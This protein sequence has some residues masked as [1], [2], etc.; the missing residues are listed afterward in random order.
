MYLVT[1]S[2]KYIVNERNVLS[3]SVNFIFSCYVSETCI[4]NRHTV[5]AIS[6]EILCEEGGCKNK[7]NKLFVLRSSFLGIT[8]KQLL[9]CLAQ[10]LYLSK[11][12]KLQT[13]KNFGA[14]EKSQCVHLFVPGM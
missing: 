9:Y 2:F 3:L 6:Q 5:C 7:I 1:G 12:A 13:A 11:S 8:F 4:S 14:C 10:V